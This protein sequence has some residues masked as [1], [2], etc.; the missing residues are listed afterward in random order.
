MVQTSAMFGGGR[1]GAIASAIHRNRDRT[2]RQQQRRRKSDTGQIDVR[3]RRYSSR[4][5]PRLVRAESAKSQRINPLIDTIAINNGT[6]IVIEDVAQRH[7]IIMDRYSDDASSGSDG[8]SNILGP[9]Q[10]KSVSA[11]LAATRQEKSWIVEFLKDRKVQ[12]GLLCL[13]LFVVISAVSIA[14]K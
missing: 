14:R 3:G 2:Q 10:R 6:Q 7:V 8:E 12:F 5:T 9:D 11:H 1:V 13:M 4:S